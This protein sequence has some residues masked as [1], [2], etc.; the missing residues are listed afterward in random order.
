M[1]GDEL[2]WCT[3]ENG[4]CNEVL[5]IGVFRKDVWKTYRRR[6][7]NMKARRKKKEE[8]EEENL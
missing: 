8:E 6:R 7:D 5:E 3:T 2:F 1:F 4:E